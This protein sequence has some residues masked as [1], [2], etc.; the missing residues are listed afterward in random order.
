MGHILNFLF[1]NNIN[2]MKS[3][4]SSSKNSCIISLEFINCYYFITFVSLFS[5]LFS[6]TIS[7]QTVSII[8]FPKSILTNISFY[9]KKLLNLFLFFFYNTSMNFDDIRSSQFGFIKG[10]SWL[11]SVCESLAGTW[12]KSD[13]LSSENHTSRH[14]LDLSHY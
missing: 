7:E 13:D 12:C 4:K 8:R 3:W 2:I 10:Y 11:D 9:L 6:W 1:W 5:H 14:M